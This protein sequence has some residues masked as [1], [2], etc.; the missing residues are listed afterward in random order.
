MESKVKKFAILGY[1]FI[2]A[3]HAAT[4]K[5]V[6]DAELVAVIEKDKKKWNAVTKGNIDVEGMEIDVLKG[7]ANTI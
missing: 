5:K 6:K 1:G 3:V 2:G 4:L 7:A